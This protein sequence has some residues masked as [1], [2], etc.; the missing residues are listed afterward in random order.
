VKP[1]SCEEIQKNDQA[2]P[3]DTTQVTGQTRHALLTP[4]ALMGAAE[5]ACC[6][7]TRFAAADSY[8]A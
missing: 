1:G 5:R 6:Q 8:L 2:W 4:E 3:G 7:G